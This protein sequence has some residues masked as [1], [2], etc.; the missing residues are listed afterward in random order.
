MKGFDIKLMELQA[1]VDEVHCC[2]DPGVDYKLER[3]GAKDD[4][5]PGPMH[6]TAH[7]QVPL[8]VCKDGDVGFFREADAKLI[9]NTMELLPELLD[10][11]ENPRDE[12][13]TMKELYEYRML[14]NAMAANAQPDISVKSLRHSDGEYCFGGGYFIVSMNLPTGQ[15]SN[16]YKLDDWDQFEIP[17]V[18]RAPEWDGHTP[19]IAADRIRAFNLKGQLWLS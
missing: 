10:R 9:V 18:E 14:Y 15:V 19:K 4:R 17:E 13:H 5:R 12:Y 2:G 16:H 7:C 3:W 1:L 11:V 8:A 6:V